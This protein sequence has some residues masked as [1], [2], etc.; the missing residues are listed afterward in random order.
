MTQR[1]T[2]NTLS[3]AGWLVPQTP[4]GFVAAAVS[5]I[6]LAAFAT[7]LHNR[8]RQPSPEQI[9]LSKL[10]NNLISRSRGVKE[11]SRAPFEINGAY[12]I[13][14]G[15]AFA[16]GNDRLSQDEF[17]ALLRDS[18]DHHLIVNLMPMDEVGNYIPDIHTQLTDTITETFSTR[19]RLGNKTLI[20]FRCWID[21]QF[22]P[23]QDSLIDLAHEIALEMNEGKVPFIHCRMGL[24]RTA[25]LIA[26]IEFM[27][28]KQNL[29]AKKDRVLQAVMMRILCQIAETAVDR[30]PTKAQL[31]MLLDPNFLGAV[32]SRY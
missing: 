3:S 2:P 13:A 20:H 1:I 5:V 12:Y 21:Q 30:V 18:P 27:R 11:Q 14:Y 26:V 6:A 24:Q 31:S 9:D 4:W 7:F 25:T 28:A 17:V 8:Y 22:V 29:K 10:S 19:S 16:R 23:E 15:P 32:I